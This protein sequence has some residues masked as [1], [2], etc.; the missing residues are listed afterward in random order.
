[1]LGFTF[2]AW[3]RDS[4]VFRSYALQNGAIDAIVSCDLSGGTGDEASVEPPEADCIPRD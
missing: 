4:C 2:E 3:V 1:M